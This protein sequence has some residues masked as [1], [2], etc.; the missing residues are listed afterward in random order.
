MLAMQAMQ[1]QIE[2]KETRFEKLIA[3]DKCVVK[4][5]SRQ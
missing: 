1:E 5:Q 4:V 3:K 2:R